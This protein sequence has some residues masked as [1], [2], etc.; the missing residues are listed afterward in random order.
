MSERLLPYPKLK[1]MIF[2]SKN[3]YS[4]LENSRSVQ[5]YCYGFFPSEKLDLKE[6][7]NTWNFYIK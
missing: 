1:C 5:F 3:M 6:R 2:E 4:I 7:I